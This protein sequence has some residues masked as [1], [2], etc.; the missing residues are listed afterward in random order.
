MEILLPRLLSCELYSGFWSVGVYVQLCDSDSLS[1]GFE[2]VV[3]Q[4][5]A[6]VHVLVRVRVCE[7][8]SEQLLQLL[9]EPY[10]PQDQLSVQVWQLCVVTGFVLFVPQLFESVHA[11]VWVPLLQVLHDPQFQFSV[12]VPG[13]KPVSTVHVGP[14]LIVLVLV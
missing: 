9:H 7:P 5:V 10:D 13:Q 4:L 3:P 2:V 14:T 12:Q 11:F 8:L 1:C 6:S